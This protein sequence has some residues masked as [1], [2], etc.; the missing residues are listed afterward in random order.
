MRIKFAAISMVLVTGSLALV[1]AY[2]GP[3][4]ASPAKKDVEQIVVRVHRREKSL[5]YELESEHHRKGDANFMLAELKLQRGGDCQIIA[6]V[7]DTVPLSAITEISE[8]A[9]NAGFKDIRPF[10]SWHKTGRMAQIQF[11]PPIKF[12]GDPEKIDQREK[13]EN[14]K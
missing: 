14:S 2:A 12:T 10:V 5:D 13:R 3:H 11:G 4:G 1:T 9:I 7:D 8:M 6:V